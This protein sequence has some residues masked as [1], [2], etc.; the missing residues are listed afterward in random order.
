VRIVGVEDRLD[1]D[2]D[3]TGSVRSTRFERRPALGVRCYIDGITN[4]VVFVEVPEIDT[5]RRIVGVC[6]RRDD[7][8]RE[9]QRDSPGY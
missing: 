4:E 2:P 6:R 5:I 7:R 3:P 1:D 8:A 9:N